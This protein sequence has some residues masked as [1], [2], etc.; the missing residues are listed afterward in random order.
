MADFL[1]VYHGSV[2]DN[3][4]HDEQ[5]A[6]MDAW[7]KWMGAI[8]AAIKD[9]GHPASRAWTVTKDGTTEDAGANPATGYSVLTAESMQAALELVMGCPQLA[10]GGSIELCELLGAGHAAIR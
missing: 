9:A 5:M 10:E 1:V 6:R 2:K 3:P 7:L 8:S 4:T